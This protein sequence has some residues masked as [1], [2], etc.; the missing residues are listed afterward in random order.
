MPLTRNLLEPA[1]WGNQYSR[2]LGFSE[3]RFLQGAVAGT[4]LGLSKAV[5]TNEYGHRRPLGPWAQRAQEIS[6]VNAA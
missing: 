4:S 6:G 2:E 5:F 1:L 3:A